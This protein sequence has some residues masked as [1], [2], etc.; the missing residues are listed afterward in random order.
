MIMQGM[1]NTVTICLSV[2][3]FRILLY[4]MVNSKVNSPAASEVDAAVQ[5]HIYKMIILH[6]QYSSWWFY[7]LLSALSAVC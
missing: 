5:A 7:L 6:S 2:H 4:S 3:A 1:F